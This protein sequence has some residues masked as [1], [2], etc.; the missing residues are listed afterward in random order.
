MGV[1][2]K[3]CLA[4]ALAGAKTQPALCLQDRAEGEVPFLMHT[5]VS[6]GLAADGAVGG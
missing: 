4:K 3:K 6:Y 1:S 2:P 5:R